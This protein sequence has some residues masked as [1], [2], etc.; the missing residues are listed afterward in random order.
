[1]IVR[2]S[3]VLVSPFDD[4]QAAVNATPEG[5]RLLLAGGTF[6]VPS[7]GLI[8]SRS[9]EIAGLGQGNGTT[10]R[11]YSTAVN[12]PV[13]KFRS[14]N[15][16]TNLMNGVYIHDLIISGGS[17]VPDHAPANLSGANGIEIAPD[18]AQLIWNVT[19]ERVSVY[20]MGDNGLYV[21]GN[22]GTSAVI[23]LRVLSCSF[24]QNWGNGMYLRGAT[25]LE[26]RGNLCASN[27]KRGAY[28]Y[29]VDAHCFG[30]YYEDNCHDA[31]LASGYDGQVRFYAGN[32][33]ASGI[34]VENFTNDGTA[35]DA[36]ST[37]LYQAGT[38]A[39]ISILNCSGFIG[40]CNIRNAVEHTD[41]NQWGMH[42]DNSA[43][44]GTVYALTVLPN[45]FELC[46]N[47]IF[48]FTP[49][50][51]LT[52]HPQNVAS[53]TNAITNRGGSIPA[54]SAY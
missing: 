26:T 12:Q 7:G 27:Y 8:I 32:I 23:G 53:G 15:A 29:E 4:L 48:F 18:S 36:R 21:T 28:F 9:I 19:L 49:N 47:A 13:I 24:T 52:V 3:V 5:G 43:A 31:T 51:K 44:G 25:L 50:A 10:L 6:T 22:G 41:P 2:P 30:D 33:A 17:P 54:W 38:K 20:G 39:G 42:I 45:R 16:Y 34:N 40:G 1:M 35:G 14:D 37:R 11:P 46:G